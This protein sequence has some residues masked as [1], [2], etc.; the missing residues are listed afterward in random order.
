[1]FNMITRPIHLRKPHLFPKIPLPF[2][3]HKWNK[4]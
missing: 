4:L 1:M 3:G 2:N